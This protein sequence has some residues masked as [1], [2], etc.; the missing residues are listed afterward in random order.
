MLC[1]TALAT[2]NPPMPSIRTSIVA[3]PRRSSDIRRMASPRVRQVR[4]SGHLLGRFTGRLLPGRADR[5]RMGGDRA[6]GLT[7]ACISRGRILEADGVW[8]QRRTPT[9]GR[10]GSMLLTSYSPIGSI[11][12]AVGVISLCLKP[13][14]VRPPDIVK[15]D[16]STATRTRIGGRGRRGRAG[17]LVHLLVRSRTSGCHAIRPGRARH[18]IG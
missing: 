4:E 7:R 6:D 16:L 3:T 12:P 5:S 17:L 9:S 14:Y 13:Q 11:T 10:A 15:A 8:S 1:S 2:S 18:S